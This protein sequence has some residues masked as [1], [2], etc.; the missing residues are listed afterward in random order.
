MDTTL[1]RKLQALGRDVSPTLLQETRALFAELHRDVDARAANVR[2]DLDYGPDP[3]HRLD[4]F[5]PGAGAPGVTAN[6]RR[7]VLIFVHG[8]GFVMGDKTTPGSPF[9]DNV[10]HWAA[11]RGWIGVTMTYRLAPAHPW[12][13]GAEDVG[14]AVR[15]VLANIE[16]FGGDPDSVFLMGQSAGA[17]HAASFIAFPA[18]QG[19]RGS[20]LAG[21]V[22]LSGI[23][24]LP[25]ADR[26]DVL[27]AY[28]GADDRVY[29]ERSSLPGL[30][31]TDL[32]LLTTVAELDGDDFQR[33]AA[34]YVAT[35]AKVR[36]RYPRMQ[37][38]SGHNH[39]SGV[40]QIGSPID[41]L[42][43]E[44]ERF[45]AAVVEGRAARARRAQGS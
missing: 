16:D 34:L 14:A 23:Y 28:F 20:G 10:G 2:R 30:V 36:Q 11:A 29:A 19:P 27:A 43:P 13:S 3:R 38:L 5:E 12:P 7:P 21:A 6:A 18:F 33:Q 25:S 31:Q 45:V 17:V 32:P 15:W 24:D 35:S 4:V 8:G 37:Y 26:N 41:T 22:L 40:L 39:L 1:R 9:Y 44:I 42:G